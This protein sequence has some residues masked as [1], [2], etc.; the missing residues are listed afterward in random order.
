[1]PA[2]A[3]IEP[4]DPLRP[5]RRW[6]VGDYLAV[7]L[8]AVCAAAILAAPWLLADSSMADLWRTILDELHPLA[9]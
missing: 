7:G 5:W 6:E 3:G 8:G 1:M 2:D 4:A 9:G